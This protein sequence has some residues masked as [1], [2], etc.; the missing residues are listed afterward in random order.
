MFLPPLPQDG[1]RGYDWIEDLQGWHALPYWGSKGWELGNW[2]Y[3]IAAVCRASAPIWGLATYIEGDTE[4][5]AFESR[6]D[7]ERRFMR[8]MPI[9]IMPC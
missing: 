1:S 3:V 7:R 5:W 4:L 8:T 6:E 2:P 9:P